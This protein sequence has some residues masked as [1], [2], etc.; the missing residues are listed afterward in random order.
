MGEVSVFFF[1]RLVSFVF[2]LLFLVCIGCVITESHEKVDAMLLENA[3]VCHIVQVL[4]RVRHGPKHRNLQRGNSLEER[5]K[6]RKR[7]E[8]KEK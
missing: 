3:K 5:G 6:K 8:R 4:K 2:V 7:K 1:I